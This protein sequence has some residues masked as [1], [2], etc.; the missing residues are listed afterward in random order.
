MR[1]INITTVICC[2][3]GV[4]TVQNAI[5]SIVNQNYDKTKYELIIIDNGSILTGHS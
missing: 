1:D 2:Y 4:K 5:E 3:H